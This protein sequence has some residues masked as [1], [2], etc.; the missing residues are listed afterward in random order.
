MTQNQSGLKDPIKPINPEDIAFVQIEK[1]ISTEDI[2]KEM[3]RSGLR[4]LTLQEMLSVEKKV[5]DREPRRIE[6]RKTDIIIDAAKVK[7]PKKL[8]T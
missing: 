6:P 7:K 2:L 5:K 1:P 3:G 4:P 8:L